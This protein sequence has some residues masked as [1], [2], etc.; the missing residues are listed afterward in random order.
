MQAHA[1]PCKPMQEFLT[2]GQIYRQITHHSTA[3][4]FCIQLKGR[5][6]SFPPY[7]YFFTQ[8]MS[9]P[10]TINILLNSY[11]H[12]Y[13]KNTLIHLSKTLQ[14]WNI[15]LIGMRYVSLP[16]RKKKIT[17]LKSPHVHKK[18]REQFELS[19]KKSRIE[20]FTKTEKQALLIVLLLLNSQFPGVEIKVNI[21]YCTPMIPQPIL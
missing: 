7:S 20:I 15:P 17:L 8:F 19:A 12:Y 3:I 14:K 5:K 2:E 9:S 13:I 1:S 18:A 6:E 16:N 10:V 11:N 4:F 21:K